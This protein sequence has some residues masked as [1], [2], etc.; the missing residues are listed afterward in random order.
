MMKAETKEAILGSLL[1]TAVGDA[2]GL[3]YE[4]LSRRRVAAL[5][6]V[7]HR[8]FFGRGMFSDD[9]EHTLMLA[10]ALKVHRDDAPTMQ[11]AFARKLRWWLLALPAG[12]G[13]STAKAIFKLWLGY[14]AAKSGVR[15]AGNGVWLAKQV[16]VDLNRLSNFSLK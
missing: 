12:V 4:G 15:S 7:R 1:G 14:P 16:P 9:T 6:A 3:S 8:F 10:K 11:R 2:L 5:G 13:L